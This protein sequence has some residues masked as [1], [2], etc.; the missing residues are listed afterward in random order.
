MVR[1]SRFMSI[2]SMWLRMRSALVKPFVLESTRIA[3]GF[4]MMLGSMLQMC[5]AE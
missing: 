3:R 5:S 4:C 1:F 2:Y